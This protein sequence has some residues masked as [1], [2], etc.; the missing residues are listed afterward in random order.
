MFTWIC[1]TCG[2][3]V[4]PAYNECPDC[5]AKQKG[6]AAPPPETPAAPVPTTPPRQAP[7]PPAK[8]GG[9]PT[10]LLSLL[11]ALLFIGIGV[12]IYWGANYVRERRQTAPAAVPFENPATKGKPHAMQKYIEITGVR[13][14]QD[15]Q[16][17]TE[18]RFLVVNHSPDDIS[19]LAGNVTIWGRTQKSDEE[20]VGTF[21]FTLP[22]IGPWESR[23]A[24]AVVVT[25]LRVYELPDWQ[26]ISADLQ[27]T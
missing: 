8:R 25:K 1:P 4:P 23:E 2:R 27:L 21:A 22:S 24:K 14:V 6:E 15:P 20:P 7:P 9:L 10:W 3:E 26:N 19:G 13:F 12:G 11:F 17:R 16:K 18:A 5:A